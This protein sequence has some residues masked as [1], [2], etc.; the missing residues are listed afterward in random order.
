MRIGDAILQ[1]LVIAGDRGQ[2]AFVRCKAGD[3]G[4]WVREAALGET[5]NAVLEEFFF[6]AGI[7][8]GPDPPRVLR[9]AVTRRA[10]TARHPRS[11]PLP[12][13]RP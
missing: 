2:R 4:G 12:A 5:D 1:E 8:I 6:R 11:P 3:H 13:G 9:S 7:A 10:S